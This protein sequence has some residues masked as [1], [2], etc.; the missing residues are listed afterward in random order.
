MRDLP[1]SHLGDFLN[2]PGGS[3]FLE[4]WQGECEA[5]GWRIAD[6]FFLANP[7][8]FDGSKF[9][10]L[11]TT[12]HQIREEIRNG[13]MV[14]P[15]KPCVAGAVEEVILDAFAIRLYALY[16]TALPEGSA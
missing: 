16:D 9:L 11:K 1:Q 2:D 8:S 10:A 12:E 13:L 14:G 15:V 3:S 6:F 5:A 4:E 7:G